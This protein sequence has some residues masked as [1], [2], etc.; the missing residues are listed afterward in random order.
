MPLRRE[1]LGES[2]SYAPK[3]KRWSK[4]TLGKN[5]QKHMQAH[6]ANQQKWYI[7]YTRK[8]TQHMWFDWRLF[9]LFVMQKHKQVNFERAIESAID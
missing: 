3:K 2:K 8:E 7:T 4:R 9:P 5:K 6:F 1:P